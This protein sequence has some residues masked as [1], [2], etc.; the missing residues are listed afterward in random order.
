M[1]ILPPLRMQVHASTL[2]LAAVS[3]FFYKALSTGQV[4]KIMPRR[5]HDAEAV[6]VLPCLCFLLLV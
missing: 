5:L 2:D 1:R 4:E 3:P 6:R